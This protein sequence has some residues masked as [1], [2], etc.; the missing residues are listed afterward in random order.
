M[1]RQKTLSEILQVF[2]HAYQQLEEFIE[3]STLEKEKLESEVGILN[4]D[5]HKAESVKAKVKDFCS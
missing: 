2:N 5:I 1:F 4:R 3:V